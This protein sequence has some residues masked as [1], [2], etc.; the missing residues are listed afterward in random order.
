MGHL[1]QV[2]TPDDE[3][4]GRLGGCLGHL[5]ILRLLGSDCQGLAGL[6]PVVASKNGELHMD[7]YIYIYIWIDFLVGGFN[8]SE[9]YKSIG[10]IIPNMGK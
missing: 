5:P 3:G 7:I 9:K 6:Q 4:K 1:Q 2:F 10:M 8:P